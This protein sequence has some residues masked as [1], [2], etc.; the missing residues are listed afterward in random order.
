MSKE[1]LINIE[2]QE[3]Q[4][5]IVDNGNLEEF[6][7][8]R[9]QHRTIVGNIYK[10][11]IES[12]VASIAACFVDIGKEKNGFLYLEEVPDILESAD[13]QAKPKSVDVKDVKKGQEVLVQVVK[14]QFGLKGPRIT[15]HIGLAGRYLVLMPQDAQRGISRRIE[16]PVERIRLHKILEELNLP[17]EMGYIV[18]TVCV[19]KDKKELARDARFLFKNWQR[20]KKIASRKHSP[21]LIYEEYDL[22]L[23]V[24]RDSFT[25]E[26]SRVVIDS[27]QE[28]RRVYGFVRSFLGPLYKRLELYQKDTPLFEHRQIEKQINNIFEAK[29]YLKCGGYLV[30][31]PTEGL[32]VIDVNSGHFKKKLSQD[33]MAFKVNSEAAEEVARQIKLRNLGGIVVI[34]FIDMTREY[35]RREVLNILKRSFE[36]D[37]AKTDIIG[38]S[39]F[40]VV[41][42]T[43]ERVY[44]TVES[45]SYQACP[46]CKGK[47]KIKSPFTVSIE[48]PKRIKEFIQ[49]SKVYKR[50]VVIEVNPQVLA[51]VDQQKNALSVI[52]HRYRRHFLI[53]PNANLHIE[54][55]IIT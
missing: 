7:V 42:M 47:G 5:A 31:E 43:R 14:E 8:E 33:E 10:G 55:I 27:K 39:K 21:A 44:Q 15:T 38:I 53:Q 48:I 30:I 54:E 52:E 25:E 28:F 49:D 23:R 19:G 26:V 46:Y 34:D 1:I 6:Y 2:S 50:D 45:M 32:V 12:V 18:R 29:A 35:Q 51:F 22:A 4:V 24:L 13:I 40:G 20:I 36:S 41:E 37:K 17:K 3:T 9:P 16:D 11:R